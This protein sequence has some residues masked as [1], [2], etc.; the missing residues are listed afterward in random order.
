MVEIDEA[1]FGKRK[2][3]YGRKVDGTWVFGGVEVGNKG[4]CFFLPVEDRSSK[5]L[6]SCIEKY[7]APGSTIISDCWRAYN[8]LDEHPDFLHLNVNHKYHFVN[9]ETGATT[10]HIER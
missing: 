4:R 6:L 1:K 7:I 5:T 9:P 10:N 3:N 2:Y 8:I